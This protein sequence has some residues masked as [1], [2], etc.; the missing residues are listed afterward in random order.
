MSYIYNI[1]IE[2][3]CVICRI[4]IL[5][6][7]FMKWNSRRDFEQDS[8]YIKNR[9][10]C[11]NIPMRCI[12]ASCCSFCICIFDYLEN[13][14]II[15]VQIAFLMRNFSSSGVTLTALT[16]ITIICMIANLYSKDK[17]FIRKRDKLQRVFNYRMNIKF[18]KYE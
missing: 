17:I 9:F 7:F 16:A 11:L 5:L 15:V 10:R 13:Q 3:S 18:I 6:Y 8:L 14:F 12:H 2:K 4:M 1:N